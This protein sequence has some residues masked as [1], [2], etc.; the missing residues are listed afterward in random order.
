MQRTTDATQNV[1]SERL[2]RAL[3]ESVVGTRLPVF[4]GAFSAMARVAL[5]SA[6]SVELTSW[7]ALPAEAL[8]DLTEAVAARVTV[9]EAAL[10]IAARISRAAEE[11]STEPVNLDAVYEAYPGSTE[12]S[13]YNACLELERE[14]L[15]E[16]LPGRNGSGHVR[17]CV[18][19]FEVLDPIVHG[20]NPRVDAA[21][22]AW[23]LLARPA[24]ESVRLAAVR[25]AL[26]WPLRRFNPALGLVAEMVAD[27]HRFQDV[28]HDGLVFTQITPDS[29]ERAE[30][31]RFASRTLRPADDLLP[32]A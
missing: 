23:E 26:D 3:V 29:V 20:C 21:L 22:L 27:A 2:A 6:Q 12:A 17:P 4:G 11:G 25:R 14:G 28:A 9:S 24:G 13:L 15:L 7:R 8:P 31:R 32:A 30:L 1:A 16:L 10:R 18:A 19:L 5:G